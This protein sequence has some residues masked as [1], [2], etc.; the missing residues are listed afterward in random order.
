MSVLAAYVFGAS[1]TAGFALIQFRAMWV[2]QV[3]G[4]HLQH[5]LYGSL[6]VTLSVFLSKLA[7]G[8]WVAS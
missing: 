5:L 1:I 8:A 3:G 2:K 4:G 7:V 6:A